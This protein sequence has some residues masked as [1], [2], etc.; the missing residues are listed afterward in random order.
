MKNLIL[1]TISALVCLS[2][3]GAWALETLAESRHTIAKSD[4]HV[5][6]RRLLDA[7]LISYTHNDDSDRSTTGESSSKSM[8]SSFE[9]LAANKSTDVIY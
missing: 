4:S 6:F 5:L 1:G 8:S 3:A 7:N 2:S 9:L